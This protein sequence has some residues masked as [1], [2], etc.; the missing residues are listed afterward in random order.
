MFSNTEPYI[1]KKLFLLTLLATSLYCTSSYAQ[2]DTVSNISDAD[3]LYGLSKFWE[4]TSYNFAYFDHTH[5]NW[6]STYRAYIPKILATKN[7]WE[8][9]LVMA[10][11]C[12]LLKDGHTDV[13]FPGQLFNE[14]GTRRWIYIENFNKHFFVT[15]MPVQFKDQIPLGSELIS[16]DGIPAKEYAE[17]EIIPYISTSTDHILWNTAA[18]RMF[19][20]TDSTQIWH[21][22]LRTPKDKIISYNYQFHTFYPKWERRNVNKPYQIIEF[23]KIGEIGYVNLNTFGDTSLISKFKAIL[24]QLYTC[25]GIILDIRENGGGDSGIGAE[26]LKYFTD[27]RLVGSTYRTRDNV[28]AYKA[29]GY[30]AMQ[31]TTSFEKRSDWDKKNILS[32]KGDYWLKGD[33]MTFDNDVHVKKLTCPLIVL[34]GNNT[35]SAAEDFLIILDGLKPR[36]TTM[37]QRTYGSTGQPM[38]ISL[39]GLSLEGRICTKRD[40]YP[41]GRD[42][43]GIGVIPDI[44]IPRTVNDV[45][46]GTDNVLDAAV[47]EIN[48]QIK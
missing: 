29:W 24:P 16:V 41:D 47:K 34:T 28:A 42:F 39:P 26:I 46:N 33:T 48:K 20:G 18:N 17:K 15:D 13:G 40:T 27:K 43:V 23:R 36:A 32:A 3:K 37:G 19:S 30:Y 2:V 38:P 25:K 10:K 9:Y 12:A 7:T 31:D 5:I 8:Y 6:D 11:F 14:N 44:E 35:G 21:L 4:E 45:I 1:M 22:T